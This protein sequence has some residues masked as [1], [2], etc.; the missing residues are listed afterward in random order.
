[1]RFDA[2]G[3]LTA[4]S[5][6]AAQVALEREGGEVVRLVEASSG[7]WLPVV[8]GCPRL[9]GLL[10][11]RAGALLPYDAEGHLWGAAPLGASPTASRRDWS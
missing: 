4:I 2:A 1:M 11:R 6:G 8:G 3:T 10:Q 7:R 5:R 9:L